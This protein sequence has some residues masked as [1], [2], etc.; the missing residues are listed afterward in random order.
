M[1]ERVEAER[2]HA[3]SVPGA[4]RAPLSASCKTSLE[5][6]GD[7]PVGFDFRSNRP[8]RGSKGAV[9]DRCVVPSRPSLCSPPLDRPR[10]LAASSSSRSRSWARSAGPDVNDNLTLPGSDSQAATDLLEKRFPSQANGTNP[11]VLTAP[12]GQEDQR[13]EV[14]AADR[15]HRVGAQAGPRRPQRDQ[16]A[17][18]QGRVA[19]VEGQVDRLHLAEPEAEPERAVDGRRGADR[20]ARRPGAQGRPRR[21]A[22]AATSARRSPS[23]RRTSAR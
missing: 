11:V 12:A 18:E 7:Q 19:A 3:K 1:C 23:P 10:R 8:N 13:V 22:S 21:S 20:R 17:V 4:R 9:D 16:P 15:R 14:Q 6:A 5:P 2:R